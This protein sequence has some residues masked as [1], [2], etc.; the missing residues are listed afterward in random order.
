MQHYR[1]VHT[2]K[3]VHITEVFA[4][5]EVFTLHRCLHSHVLLYIKVYGYIKDQYLS[6]SGLKKSTYLTC[7]RLISLSDFQN[8]KT[9]RFIV[10][11]SLLIWKVDF[12][13]RKSQSPRFV[14]VIII[15]MYTRYYLHSNGCVT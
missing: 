11:V 3:D 7:L 9:L 13:P 5:S 6:I 15:M 10:F 14:C 1:G 2:F 12:T 4:L 8:T